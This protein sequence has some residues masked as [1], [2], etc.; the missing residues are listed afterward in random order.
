[1]MDERRGKH[2]QRPEQTGQTNN[3]NQKR[4]NKESAVHTNAEEERVKKESR[5]HGYREPFSP[6]TDGYWL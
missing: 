2:G 5:N 1:M 3:P 6:W 4:P